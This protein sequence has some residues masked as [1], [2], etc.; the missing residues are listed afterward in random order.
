MITGSLKIGNIFFE[1]QMRKMHIAKYEDFNSVGKYIIKQQNIQNESVT[2]ILYKVKFTL[3][4]QPSPRWFEKAR[5]FQLT[6]NELGGK[7]G[8]QVS[9]KQQIRIIYPLSYNPEVNTTF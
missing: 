2:P 9:C 5:F 4:F 8:K 6:S 3:R 1:L 7:F